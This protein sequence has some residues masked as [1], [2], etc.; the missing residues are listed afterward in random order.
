MVRTLHHNIYRES[1]N[2]TIWNKGGSLNAEGLVSFDCSLDQAREWMGLGVALLFLFI[3]TFQLWSVYTK[4]GERSILAQPVSD[5]RLFVA[6]LVG[7]LIIGLPFWRWHARLSRECSV[8]SVTRFSRWVSIIVFML[9]T[10]QL[11]AS[12][13][14]FLFP[15]AA[16]LVQKISYWFIRVIL[17]NPIST[18][19]VVSISVFVLSP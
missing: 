16:E 10:I 14:S 8:L 12:G 5:F 3:L 6:L 11:S 1:L 18:L 2:S 19:I 17:V 7:G 9:S 4:G 15:S 13:I